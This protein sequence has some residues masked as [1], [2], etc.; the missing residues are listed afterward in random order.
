[1]V[2]LRV[3][4]IDADTKR[5]A[6]A[7][8]DTSGT[9]N[10]LRSE[11]MKKLRILR[12]EHLYV[13]GVELTC[14]EELRDGDHVTCTP[15]KRHTSS[16]RAS[17]PLHRSIELRTFEVH[18]LYDLDAERQTCQMVFYVVF[19]FPNGAN[20][21]HLS[22][23]L[24]EPSFPI[25]DDGRPTFRP[26][27]AWYMGKIDFNNALRHKVLDRDVVK[28]GPDIELRM[29]FA[30]TFQQRF[31]VDDFP[32]DD[33]HITISLGL[34]CRRNG[35]IPTAFSLSDKTLLSIDP[36]GFGLRMQWKL[37]RN[38]FVH[39]DASSPTARPVQ[40][41]TNAPATDPSPTLARKDSGSQ[42]QKKAQTPTTN[43]PAQR[44]FPSI[45][46]T[47]HVRRIPMHVLAMVAF[48]ASLMAVLSLLMYALAVLPVAPSCAIHL[49]SPALT[50]CGVRVRCHCR[51][52][53]PLQD[54]GDRTEASLT[55]VLTSFASKLSIKS[56]LPE[57]S[58]ST[59]LD[60]FTFTCVRCSRSHI[61]TL[62]APA[63][64][65]STARSV[66]RVA[67]GARSSCWPLP[68][69]VECSLS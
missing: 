39:T 10:A 25:G 57:A 44:E 38:I 54:A 22:E 67:S 9:L 7:L 61:T 46:F 11:A 49:A 13:D 8:I 43:G 48:P 63:C 58:Y 3:R 34:N 50:C 27:A 6:F 37:D 68:S 16:L 47:V 45:N 40:Y 23:P 56:L 36:A 60:R 41:I 53:L 52:T 55:L 2:M 12:P 29:R 20:D 21:P 15:T 33:Q 64:Q 19:C 66:D 32:F 31:E 62:A 30:G 24:S 69:S 59:L 51:F 35:P 26:N 42:V 14:I 18:S 65:C 4:V 5:H 17:K 1:M 28:S